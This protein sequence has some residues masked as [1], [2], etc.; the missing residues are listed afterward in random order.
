[1]QEG[2]TSRRAAETCSA[3]PRWTIQA[4]IQ[5]DDALKL[6]PSV[7][8]TCPPIHVSTMR[9][10]LLPE[11]SARGHSQLRPYKLGKGAPALQYPARQLAPAKTRAKSV[12]RLPLP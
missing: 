4:E 2:H 9:Q 6:P 10:H 11:N 5:A 3:S 1:M 7:V 12:R 8:I